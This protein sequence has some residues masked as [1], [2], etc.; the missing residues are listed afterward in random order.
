MTEAN[1]EQTR[2][3]NEVAG[4]KWVAM[5]RQLDAQLESLG[6]AGMA[7]LEWRA[8]DRVLDVG[9]GAGATTL[10]LARRV[11]PGEVVGVD[12]SEPLVALARRRAAGADNL[13]FELG[14]A[15]TMRFADQFDVVYSRFGVMFFDDPVAAFNNLRESLRPG[16]RLAVVCWRA[17]E[18]NP[19]V[20]AP[21]AA[22]RSL[23][24]EVPKPTPPGAPGPFAFAD[25]Q[26]LRKILADAGFV[27]V[28]VRAHDEDMV[29][30]G[31][32]MEAAVHS[33]TQIGPLGAALNGASTELREQA[34]AAVRAMFEQHLGPRGVTFK[35]GVWLVLA[36]SPGR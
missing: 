32:G 9:C 16:G 12:V 7:R 33:V 23:L 4:P 21:L 35:A 8:G 22:A 25:E 6:E 24:P 31:E 2:V 11:A 15:Q 34:K 19:W 17:M 5:Q 1:L 3:W 26:R 36:R 28:E 20:S 10:A 14:D 27:D 29:L 30:G 13:R 18:A